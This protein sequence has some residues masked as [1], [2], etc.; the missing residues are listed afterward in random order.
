MIDELKPGSGPDRV[1]QKRAERAEQARP[2]ADRE[3]PLSPPPDHALGPN[4]HA[5]LDG[6][7]PEAAARKN[8][9][10]KDVEFWRGL[11]AE[12]ARVR[13]MRTPSHCE[14]QI[15]AALPTHAP[16]AV[17]TQWYRREF[18][19]TPARAVVAAVVLI[20]VASVATAL[21]LR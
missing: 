1:G 2:L 8:E 21:L 3:V 14:A 20:T 18:V 11:D 19:I 17:I 9:H 6:E 7:L 5:W 15:M 12:M 10:P 13:R 4:V 16:S